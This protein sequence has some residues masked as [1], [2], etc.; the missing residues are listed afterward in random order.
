[1][2]TAET[3]VRDVRHGVRLLRRDPGF[4]LTALATLAVGIGLTTTIFSVAYGVLWRALP[5]AD[6]DRL[7]VLSSLQQSERGPR[8][9]WTWA[10]VSY[11]GLRDNADTFEQIAAYSSSDVSLTGRGEPQQLRALDVSPNFL[12]LLGVTPPYGRRFLSDGSSD[13][14]RSAILSDRLWRTAF[15]GDPAITGRAIT[16]DGVPRTVVGVLPADFSFR[17]VIGIG[18]LPEPDVY[19][20]NRWANDTGGSAFLFLLGRLKPG[21]ARARAE[22]ELTSLV[23]DPAIAAAGAMAPEGALVA[24]GRSRAHVTGLQ[25]RGTEPVR[26]LLLVLLGAVSFVLL[27]ACVNVANLQMARLTAR[28]GE[29]SVR[30]AVGASRARL[31]RQLLTE[32]AILSVLGA[33]LGVALA[34]ITLDMTLPFVPPFLLPR[35]GGILIDGRVLA[36]ALGVSIASTMLIGLLPA[37]RLGAAAF[38]EALALQAGGARTTSDRQGERLRALLV[39]GQVAV[40]LVLLIGAGLLVHSF[41]RLSS[42]S[43]GFELEGR[44][45][46]VQAVRVVLPE[47]L[48]DRPAPMKA[49]TSS[50]LDRIRLLPGVKSASVVNSA[51]F[52]MMYI[53]SDFEIEGLPKPKL[54]AGLPKIH[55][56][57]FATMGIP[58]LAGRDFSSGD[59]PEAPKVAIISERLVRESFPGGP[60]E[61]IGRRVRV[62]DEEDWMTVVGVVADIRHMG[63]DRDVQPMLYVPYQQETGALFLRFVSFVARTPTPGPVSEAMRA[64]VRRAAPDLVIQGAATMDEAVAA[65]VAPPRFRMVLLVLFA[66]AAMLIATLGIHG[67]M[68]YA[69]AQRRR[70]IA[71]RM[72]LGAERRDVLLFVLARALRIVGAG[73]VLGLVGATVMTRVLQRFLFGVTPTDPAAF[74]VVTAILLVVAL[75]AAWVPARRATRIDPWAAL[76]VD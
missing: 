12:A 5:F 10:P 53:Q 7:V 39:A 37:T 24:N 46:V 51:P 6:P 45:G 35:T 28:R 61:A 26:R 73:L 48:Y 59:T 76:H 66:T 67:L 17:P 19:F 8:T 38:S 70:E 29:L 47:H 55:P 16:I 22:A 72:A 30:L 54:F 62:V 44:D 34:R 63:L 20:P 71:L 60:G 27:I 56:G 41:V 33:A 69:V 32:A 25:E 3:L 36:F 13:D 40:T 57:Y 52:G 18:A 42:V 49:F 31:V 65:S 58:L 64:E 11:Q 4:T 43:P 14:D 15:R 21:V 2:P 23:N 68:A 75:L 50:V 1:M 9:I 74:G